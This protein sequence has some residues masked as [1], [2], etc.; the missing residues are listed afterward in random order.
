L[1]GFEVSTYGRFS[2]VHRGGIDPWKFT[3][4]R[5]ERIIRRFLLRQLSFPNCIAALDAALAGVL[6]RLKPEQLDEVRAVMLANNG[7]V[8]DEMARRS[9]SEIPPPPEAD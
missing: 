5:P 9:S 6:P 7:R 3:G 2:D 4:A 1:A 8:M